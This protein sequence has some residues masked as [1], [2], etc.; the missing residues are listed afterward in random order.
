MRKDIFSNTRRN[1]MGISI[2]IVIGTLMIFAIITQAMYEE[3]LFDEADQQLLTHKNMIINDA[4]IQYLDGDVLEVILPSPLVKELINYVW[5]DGK[6]IKE[7][8]H[9]YKGSSKYPKF[10]N[11]V[12][13]KIVQIQD[14]QY[15]YRGIQFD[16]EGCKVQLLLSV[17]SQIASLK[18][19][20]YALLKAFCILVVV[21]LIVS[22][23]LAKIA[24][25]PLYRAYNKQAAFIQDASHEMRTP[26]AVI[27]GK[28]EIIVRT[29]QDKIETHY[30]E[31]SG[32]MCE[33]S[34]LEKLNKDLLLLSKEDMGGILEIKKTTIHSFFKEIVEFYS[35]LSEL[36][37]LEFLYE[38]MIPSIEIE[39]DLVKVK[40]CIG[41]LLENA[42]KYS[43]ENGRIT[44]KVVDEDKLIK[45]IVSD[46]GRGI[47]EEELKKIF[48]RFYR[49]NEVRALGIEGS[50]IG[51]SLLK[52]LAYTMN[53]KIK[54]E[55]EYGKGSS[56]ILW[57]P[58][59]MTNS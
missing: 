19:L 55:S 59:K 47:S 26:L 16:Y 14:A 6:L 13:N 29:P 31:I 5:K 35:A 15:H 58:K 52:S 3:N 36:H 20:Q 56:F 10:P 18:S 25:K 43:N 32:I 4:H 41:I 21:G 48:N 28:L 46:T 11:G 7:S 57:I 53:I 40:R 54:V 9:P 12:M 39:W 23:Y 33:I 42:I 38:I 24:L 27:K 50:G 49:S 44:L 37:N 17:D 1:I 2:G 30:D 51:L 8:P 34:G 45:V 22:F